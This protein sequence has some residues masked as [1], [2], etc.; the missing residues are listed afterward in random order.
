MWGSHGLT[1]GASSHEPLYKLHLYQGWVKILT[2]QMTVY[3]DGAQLAGAKLKGCKEAT[4]NA[5]WENSVPGDPR[6]QQGWR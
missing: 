5:C 2:F 6:R 3:L 4:P 1:T